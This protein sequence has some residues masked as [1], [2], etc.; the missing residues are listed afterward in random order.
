[1][2]SSML[3]KLIRNGRAPINSM[4]NTRFTIMPIPSRPFSLPLSAEEPD[5]DQVLDQ[6]AAEIATKDYGKD[7]IVD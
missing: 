3:L 1:M 7:F 2:A 5:K 4:I 6:R